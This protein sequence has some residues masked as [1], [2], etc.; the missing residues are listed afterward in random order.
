MDWLIKRWTLGWEPATC[1]SVQVL[2]KALQ[3]LRLQN[4]AVN[5]KTTNIIC[6]AT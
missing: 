5:N 2:A 1:F 3:T 4:S 6:E